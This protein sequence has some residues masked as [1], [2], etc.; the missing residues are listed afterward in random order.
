[1]SAKDVVRSLVLE[2]EKRGGTLSK[3]EL[4]AKM[5]AELGCVNVFEGTPIVKM[6]R[7]DELLNLV[8]NY[9]YMRWYVQMTLDDVRSLLKAVEEEE[10]LSI[11]PLIV[12]QHLDDHGYADPSDSMTEREIKELRGKL[13]RLGMEM[14]A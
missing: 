12:D 14:T 8:Q 4:S 13:K 11:G 3:V 7:R 2:A 5:Y 1:M 10:L 9:A 6:T